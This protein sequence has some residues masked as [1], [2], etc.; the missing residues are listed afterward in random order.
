MVNRMLIYVSARIIFIFMY[1]AE[2]SRIAC[3]LI[4]TVLWTEWSRVYSK[5]SSLLFNIYWA[6]FL[7]VKWPG[8]VTPSSTKVKYDWSQ[9]C[10]PPPI[11][12]HGVHNFIQLNELTPLFISRNW[13]KSGQITLGLTVLGFEGSTLKMLV[14]LLQS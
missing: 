11:R 10:P 9:A 6:S 2:V 13:V 8:C 4:V 7:G 14:T 3:S 5:T 1:A 12:L